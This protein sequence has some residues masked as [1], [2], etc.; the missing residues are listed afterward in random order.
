M[1]TD[2]RNDM[3]LPAQGAGFGRL[4]AGI[5]R[6]FDIAA[7]LGSLVIFS[8]LMLGVWA[9]IQIE[10][11]S[12]AIF[13]QKRI[14]KGGQE[15]VLLK[16]RSM[17][18][19]S[20]KNGPQ[21]SAAGGAGDKRLTKVGAWIRAHHLDELP[22]LWNVLK[23]DMS[24]VGY[25]P[26]RQYFINQIIERRPDYERLYA[27]RP[28][29]FSKATLYNGYCDTIEKMIT[30]L[31]MDLEYLERATMGHDIKIIWLTATSIISGKKF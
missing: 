30:R 4:Q 5:K 7:S 3:T 15:F 18:R 19:T 14:G 9:A 11:G 23:G 24:F 20:E 12:P 28:G 8:P 31:D 29:L 16:F 2:N 10:D 25:R 17:V 26:E 27:I 21:L 13:R 1:R 22:Q 6:G